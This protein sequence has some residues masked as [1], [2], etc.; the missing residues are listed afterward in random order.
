MYIK[1][2]AARLGGTSLQAEVS[3]SPSQLVA[4]FGRPAEEKWDS[5]SLGAYYFLGEDELVFAVYHRAH[6]Q[7]EMELKL[8]RASFWE[9]DQEVDFSIAAK[10]EATAISF[11]NWLKSQLTK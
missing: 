3:A 9:Q 7:S 11:K 2:E 8:L 4:L 10:S 1:V 5:E 6:D